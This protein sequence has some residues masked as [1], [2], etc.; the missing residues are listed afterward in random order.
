MPINS[1]PPFALL[2]NTLGLTSYGKEFFKVSSAL[3]LETKI[4]ELHR[5]GSLSQLRLIGEGSNL[6]LGPLI[7]GPLL[8]LANLGKQKIAETEEFVLVEA[9]AGENWNDFVQWTLGKNY[10]G[11]EN[12]SLIP[13]TVGAAPFQNIGAYGVELRDCLHSVKVYDTKHFKF[14]NLSEAECRFS[15][16]DS[17][18]KS[19]EPGRYVI[20]SVVFALP[21]KFQP[22]LAYGELKALAELETLTPQMV[23]EK[24]I[25]IRQS[26]LPS[27]VKIGNAGSFFKN[28][29]VSPLQYQEL[30]KVF[31]NLVV[32]PHGT[33]YKLSAGWLIEQAG[34]KG[35]S[36]GPVGMYEKQALVLVNHGM[37]TAED[38]WN[39]SHAVQ[40]S[41]QDRFGVALEPEPLRWDR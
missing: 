1:Q 40:K 18:F 39:L 8:G 7:E 20:W 17:V 22:Q 4:L 9:Q 28:P 21:K 26:K 31:A 11:L 23:A 29:V 6:V 27:P 25:E 12:L 13:G 2:P 33:N 41:V 19:I 36:L 15:Y 34:W 35:Q 30:K 5:K 24:V 38:V 10:S 32:Y 3:E 14:I 16:R 37:A